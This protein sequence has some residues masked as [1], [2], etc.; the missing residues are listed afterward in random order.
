ML[1]LCIALPFPAS[2]VQAPVSLSLCHFLLFRLNI[3]VYKELLCFFEFF[4]VSS[5]GK[6]KI[7]LLQEMRVTRKILTRAVAS[8][9]FFNQIK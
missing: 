5:S 4:I 8:Q 1:K 3:E 6:K 2:K 7:L 9:F